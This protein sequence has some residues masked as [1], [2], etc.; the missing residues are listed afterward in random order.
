MSWQD[1]LKNVITQGR[2]K[3]IE[4]IDIDIEDD[5]CLRWLKKLYN[6]ILRHPEVVKELEINDEKSA[7]QVKE[8]CEDKSLD[9]SDPIV[10]SSKNSSSKK[11]RRGRFYKDNGTSTISLTFYEI[12]ATPSLEK[13]FL[14][15]LKTVTHTPENSW[16]RN[17]AYFDSTEGKKATKVVRELC[18]YLDFDFVELMERMYGA[19]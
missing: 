18:D 17:A 10:W 2:V 7:C 16:V 12:Y 3:E 14:I 11:D 9:D 4:D 19:E 13:K 15:T 1:I 8:V 6:I 5:D